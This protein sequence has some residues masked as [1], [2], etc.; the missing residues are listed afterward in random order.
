MKIVK[1]LVRLA[2]AGLFAAAEAVLAFD[3]LPIARLWHRRQHS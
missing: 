2:V 3:E 1:A